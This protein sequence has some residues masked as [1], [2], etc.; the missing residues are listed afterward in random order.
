M[1]K[2]VFS[3]VIILIVGGVLFLL[4][5][6][7]GKLDSFWG[8]LGLALFIFAMLRLIQIRRIKTNE[9]YAEKWSIASNDERN[10]YIS[11]EARSK[12]FNFSMMIQAITLIIFTS[13]NMTEYIKILSY[14]FVGQLCIYFALYF[15]LRKIA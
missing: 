7:F 11:K 2:R 12:A 4:S 3:Y 6:I 9:E 8:G 10:I 13:L 1:E 5:E 15:V 14:L